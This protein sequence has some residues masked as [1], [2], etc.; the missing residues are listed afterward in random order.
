MNTMQIIYHQ[1]HSFAR[2][3]NINYEY[4][5]ENF[6]RDIHYDWSNRRSTRDS[7]LKGENWLYNKIEKYNKNIKTR[8]T[9][10]IQKKEDGTKY[11][12][13]D[14]NTDQCNIAFIIMEKII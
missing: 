9:I 5:G 1:L 2:T 3:M 11:S 8:E 6:D 14:L 7:D 4:Y 12:F 13:R 10:I